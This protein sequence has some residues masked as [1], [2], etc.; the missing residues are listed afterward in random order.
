[1]TYR[2][3]LRGGELFEDRPVALGHGRR[4]LLDIHAGEAFDQALVVRA[5]LAE[6]DFQVRAVQQR[7]KLLVGVVLDRFIVVKEPR[8][9]VHL[10]HPL[11]DLEL[12]VQDRPAIQGLAAV[13]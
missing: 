1:M 9:R 10:P 12:R 2:A 4:V 13:E 8:E 6:G 5:E 3:S 11:A 7:L